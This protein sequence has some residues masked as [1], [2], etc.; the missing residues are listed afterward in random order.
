MI[1]RCFVQKW[2]T[3]VFALF[4]SK[5][6]C[7]HDFQAEIPKSLADKCCLRLAVGEPVAMIVVSSCLTI[8][9]GV[10]QQGSRERCLP[11]SFFFLKMKRKQKRKKTERNGKKTEENGKKWKKTEENGKKRKKT[12]RKHRK[13]GKKG[14]KRK[15]TEKNGKNRK[16]HRSGDPFCETP[17]Q[18]VVQGVPFTRVQFIR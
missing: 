7:S 13:N 5:C 10:S 15:K 8:S 17:I 16:R 1:L 12:E 2:R 6:R 14:R 4:A 11:V 9:S 3:H 18:A